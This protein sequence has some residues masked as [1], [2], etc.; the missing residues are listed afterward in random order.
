LRA[1]IEQPEAG[2]RMIDNDKERV[3]EAGRVDISAA[4]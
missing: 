3:I 4:N 1:N 2:L